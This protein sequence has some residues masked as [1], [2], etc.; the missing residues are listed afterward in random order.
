LRCRQRRD[1]R[2]RRRSSGGGE[3]RSCWPVHLRRL[4]ASGNWELLYVDADLEAGLYELEVA[5]TR[6]AAWLRRARVAFRKGRRRWARE[7]AALDCRRSRAAC[8]ALRELLRARPPPLPVSVTAVTRA[9]RVA[10]LDIRRLLG[11][12]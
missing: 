3:C 1:W 8:R 5:G 12:R 7:V 9:R 4:R 2:A 11:Q 6:L 10:R